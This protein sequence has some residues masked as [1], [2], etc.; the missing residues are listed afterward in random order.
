MLRLFTFWHAGQ[1]GV[2]DLLLI[3]LIRKLFL[4]NTLITAMVLKV[5]F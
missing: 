1:M 3:V 2:A 4:R 5:Y